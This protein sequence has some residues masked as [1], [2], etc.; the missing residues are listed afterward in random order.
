M[1]LMQPTIVLATQAPTLGVLPSMGINFS[2]VD[3][4]SDGGGDD[5]DAGGDGA[6]EIEG[7]VPGDPDMRCGEDREE[8]DSE[9]HDNDVILVTSSPRK[10]TRQS[11]TALSTSGRDVEAGSSSG[12][13][14]TGSVKADGGSKAGSPH[15]FSP[16][17]LKMTPSMTT[18]AAQ[19][20]IWSTHTLLDHPNKSLQKTAE[21]SDDKA[22]LG[23][24]ASFDNEGQSTSPQ[25]DD[26]EEDDVDSLI[27]LE[28]PATQVEREVA[29]AKIRPSVWVHDAA[30]VKRIKQK[31]M[32]LGRVSE[33]LIFNLFNSKQILEDILD[34]I[35]S[36]LSTDVFI[37]CHTTAPYQ[38]NLDLPDIKHM[39]LKFKYAYM[40]QICHT[41]VDFL[42][43]QLFAVVFTPH[44][45]KKHTIPRVMAKSR[46]DRTKSK[47][48]K[49]VLCNKDSTYSHIC[50]L[51]LC[52]ASGCGRCFDF[53]SFSW[54]DLREHFKNCSAEGFDSG[55][56]A[57]LD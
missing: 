22:T 38:P 3:S 41:S 56:A 20:L 27:D 53:V 50:H 36:R 49:A 55:L 24:T 35:V 11:V 33:S 43:P 44:T 5:D 45:I 42:V 26:V 46:G 16:D 32:P 17:R 48:Y 54:A 21:P 9:D 40:T 28:D 4:T 8:E 37:D 34:L 25:E 29:V 23:H 51:H 39:Y 10:F 30:G 13:V 18:A 47:E 7:D 6:Q 1:P 14:A 2:V 19:L 52:M 12:G 57:R 31:Q 15:L